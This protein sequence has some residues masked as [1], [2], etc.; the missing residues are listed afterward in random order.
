MSP[1]VSGVH[2]P[3]RA[4]VRA[5]AHTHTPHP[6]HI[7]LNLKKKNE[8]KSLKQTLNVLL[9]AG[10]VHQL[11]ALLGQEIRKPQR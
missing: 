2:I 11:K 10:S 9:L 1:F 8:K 3:G 4:R 6:A 5:N 7:F